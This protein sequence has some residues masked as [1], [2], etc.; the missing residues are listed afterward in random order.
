MPGEKL[1]FTG[2]TAFGLIRMRKATLMRGG[3]K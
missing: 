2:Y 1:V 3:F